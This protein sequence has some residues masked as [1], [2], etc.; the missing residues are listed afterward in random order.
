MRVLGHCP[1]RSSYEPRRVA[2]HSAI[3][4]VRGKPGPERGGVGG[5][6]DVLT[7]VERGAQLCEPALLGL[8]KE[9]VVVQPGHSQC[10]AKHLRSHGDVRVYEECC[11]I[12]GPAGCQVE[13]QALADAGEKPGEDDRAARGGIR[14]FIR[15]SRRAVQSNPRPV[16]RVL[17]FADQRLVEFDRWI[18]E[19]R[20]P[21]PNAFATWTSNLARS[22]P[23]D[24]VI[25]LFRPSRA[26]PPGRKLA[27]ASSARRRRC[28]AWRG[29]TC[30]R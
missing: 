24:I 12:Q 11:R 13:H 18:V 8:A 21:Q 10:V 28:S 2:E 14:Y 7:A 15:F 4:R 27:T 29:R 16:L 23:L 30:R 6:H 5:Q 25:R 1:L 19:K 20:P 3:T 9:S 22:T 17:P 26:R